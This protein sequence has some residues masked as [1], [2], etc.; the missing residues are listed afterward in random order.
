MKNYLHYLFIIIGASGE[1]IEKGKFH[2]IGRAEEQE[3][4]HTAG[5]NLEL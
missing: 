2:A 3:I 5:Y 1:G 4:R